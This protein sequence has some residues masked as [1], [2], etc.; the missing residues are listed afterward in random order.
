MA[1]DLT[2]HYRAT[3]RKVG[4][5]WGAAAIGFAVFALLWTVNLPYRR[6]FQPT[7]N[8]AT[9]LADALLLLPGAHWQDWFTQGYRNFFESYPEWPEQHLTAFARPGFQFLIYI[10]HF[11]FGENWASYLAI[12]YLGIA[13]VAAVAFAIA[14]KPLDLGAA[15]SVFAAM[16][17]SLSPAVLDSSI[18]ELGF[19]SESLASFFAGCA[20][21]AVIAR[22]DFLC[23]VLLFAALLMKETVVWCPFAAA[24]TALLRPDPDREQLKRALPAAAMLLPVALWLG[25]RVAFFE[26]IG[27]TY[28]TA[29]YTPLGVFLSLT[30]SKLLRLHHLFVAQ[31]PLRLG[32]L[33]WDRVLRFAAGLPVFLLLA[34]WILNGLREASGPLV[35]G[36]RTRRWPRAEVGTLVNLW[37]AAGLAFFFALALHD[38]RYAASGVMFAWPAMVR[39]ALRRRSLLPRLALAVCATLS[40]VRVP[41]LLLD[42][43]PP[44]PLSVKDRFFTAAAAMNAALREVPP[45]IGQVYVVPADSMGWDNPEYLRALL[46]V[47]AQIIR[48]AEMEWDC[49]DRTGFVSLDHET[50]AGTI[51]L[52]ATVPDCARFFLSVSGIDSDALVDGRLNRG[53]SIAYDMP[54]ATPSAGS[55]TWR[56]IFDPPQ[57]LTVHIRPQGRARFLIEHGAPDGGLAWFDTP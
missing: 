24:V 38:E 19:A 26:G 57:R 39:E 8:D 23:V 55:G 15:A 53:P 37:A 20:F 43:N 50:T 18:W 2:A 4:P 42:R 14:R 47:R 17:A 1:A 3:A 16:L 7:D 40:L 22:R 35:R 33:H 9:N 5:A 11:V 52:S 10:A 34:L 13:G 41:G 48:V 25:L 51:T 6:V 46:G 29:D 30:L 45:E 36:A 32:G 54:N 56:P 49:D 12:N 28:A 44:E 31:Y 21:L 27:G